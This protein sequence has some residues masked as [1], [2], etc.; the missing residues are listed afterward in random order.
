MLGQIMEWFYSDL[1]GLAPD[2][3]HPGFAQ[4]KIRPQPVSE[5]TWARAAHRSPRGR[6]AVE[7][8]Q[9]G[10]V[11]SLE[12]E[13]PPNTSAAVWMPATAPGAVQEGGQ[14]LDE[15][16]GVRVLRQE[17]DRIVLEVTSG[18]YQFSSPVP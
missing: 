3:D 10:S 6:V 16:E 13:L 9:E 12:V 8:R 18:Q 11:F 7:W 4:V 17:G 2:E 1:A 5:I 15:V 14:A